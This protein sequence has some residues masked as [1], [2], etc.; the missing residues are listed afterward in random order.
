MR[1]RKQ[2]TF[3]SCF[4]GVNQDCTK[5]QFEES[6]SE[7]MYHLSSN[8]NLES[9]EK[10][11]ILFFLFFPLRP[12]VYMDRSMVS[13][14]IKMRIDRYPVKMVIRMARIMLSHVIEQ[15]KVMGAFIDKTIN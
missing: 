14:S 13:T 12:F 2:S 1:V 6:R 4:V 11:I 5:N 10:A 7:W 9:S 8:T 3:P 15:C